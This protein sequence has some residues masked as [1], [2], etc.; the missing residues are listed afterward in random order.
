VQSVPYTAVRFE[1]SQ[2]FVMV[3]AEG[4][5]SRRTVILGRTFRDRVEIVDGLTTADRVLVSPPHSLRDGDAV[6]EAGQ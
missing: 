5:A 1:G 2:A 4:V 6:R 3:L